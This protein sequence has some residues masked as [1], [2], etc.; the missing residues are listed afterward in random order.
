MFGQT[1]ARLHRS[2]DRY[3]FEDLLRAVAAPVSRRTTLA[4]GLA[5]G[6]AL[7]QPRSS[8]QVEAKRKKGK[9]KHRGK[10]KKG[11]DPTPSCPNRMKSANST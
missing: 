1:P 7:T 9:G 4:A 5:M 10:G 3:R 6:L 8:S 11:K 2:L